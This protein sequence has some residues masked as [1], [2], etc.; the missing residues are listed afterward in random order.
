MVAILVQPN[1]P[2]P[3]LFL[4]CL[5]PQFSC[6]L[7]QYHTVRKLFFYR[8]YLTIVYT[9]NFTVISVTNFWKVYS[10]TYRKCVYYHTCLANSC[11]ITKRRNI[12]I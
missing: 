1:G 7:Q 12:N 5:A 9:K 2:T 3:M 10:K 4:K 6:L 11:V 8:L